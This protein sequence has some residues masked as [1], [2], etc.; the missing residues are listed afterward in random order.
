MSDQQQS[1]WQAPDKRHTT[2]SPTRRFVRDWDFGRAIIF[3]VFIFGATIVVGVGFFVLL[4]FTL[5]ALL[6]ELLIYLALP[7]LLSRFFATG[8]SDWTQRPNL[9]PAA[10][11]SILLAMLGLVVLISNIPVFVD[12]LFPMPESYRQM[13]EDMLT[14]NTWG[15]YVLLLLVVA[16]VPGLCEEIA[17]RGV[18]YQGI[19]NTFGPKPA[20]LVSSVLFAI[21]HLSVWNF[22][23][24]I[25]MGLFLG[26]LRERSGSIWPGVVA[27]VTNNALALTMFTLSPPAE[28]AWH[29]EYFPLWLNLLAV[30]I[31]V[32]GMI[33]FVRMSQRFASGEP[34]M[35]TNSD[36]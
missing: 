33:G 9:S 20:L 29:Y 31:L 5:S 10:W 15:E 32:L 12:E 36:G 4:G 18:I 19:R 28:N 8:W 6:S 2:P 23:A 35:E 25:L 21:I 30:S 22:A 16:V 26:Y 24:L 7:L 11:G 27:H 34:E 1:Q 13:F 17:F 14:A 3:Y